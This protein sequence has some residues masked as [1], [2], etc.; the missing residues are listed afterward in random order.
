MLKLKLLGFFSILLVIL[1]S[2]FP[3]FIFAD[4]EADKLRQL[5]NQIQE[6]KDKLAQ[7]QGTAQTLKATINVLNNKIYLAQAEIDST[8]H[9]IQTLENEI[10][11]L[12]T[13]IGELDLLL[14]EVAII[15]EKRIEE[16]YKRTY[17]P[18]FQIVLS[19]NSFTNFLSQ[20]QYVKIA[21]KND[22]ENMFKM[23]E[24]KADFS[25]KKDL[26]EKKQ[27]ELEVLRT[28]L[29]AQKQALDWQKAAKNDLLVQTQNDEATYQSLLAQAQ[30]EFLAIQAILAGRGVEEEIGEVKAG[31]RIASVIV[32]RS[33]NSSGTHLHFTIAQGGKALNP[34]NYLKPI[35]HENCSGPGQCSA[36]DPFNPSGSWDWPLAG[37]IRMTQGYGASWAVSNTWVGSIYSFHNGIDISG[38]STTI[39]A[40]QDG[41]LYRGSYGG[42]GGCRLRYVRLDHSNSDLDSFYLHVN[43]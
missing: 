1:T 10:K 26:K 20:L 2:I 33:C 24:I 12:S 23:E 5:E 42:A 18:Y 19:S 28:S 30:A 34:F 14:D 7:A 29:A 15:L 21:Q 43:Y 16:T 39:K 27:Q 11:S 13:K 3:Y 4:E 6:Y 36:S 40:I 41:T 38:S 37:P 25:S 35:D 32:G 17:L 22:K 8:N 9:Q 31:D